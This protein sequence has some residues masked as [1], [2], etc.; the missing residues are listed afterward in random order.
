M[1]VVPMVSSTPQ[2]FPRFVVFLPLGLALACTSITGEPPASVANLPIDAGVPTHD[3]AT[4]TDAHDPSDAGAS[5]PDVWAM[6]MVGTRG[7]TVAAG[8]ATLSIPAGAL[9]GTQPIT[10]R[11]LG[12][13]PDGRA[14]EDLYQLS[15]AG[16]TF[17]VP[18]E[19][20]I[21]LG[22]AAEPDARLIITVPG[23]DTE[24]E[25][26][27]TTVS[28]RTLTA[29]ITH[30]SLATWIARG[31]CLLFRTPATKAGDEC[32]QGDHCFGTRLSCGDVPGGQ[33][34]CVCNF[35]G[36]QPG[37]VMCRGTDT[38]LVCEENMSDGCGEWS[39]PRGCGAREVCTCPEGRICESGCYRPACVPESVFFPCVGSDGRAVCASYD[40]GYRPR[41]EDVV[42]HCGECDNE[43]RRGEPCTSGMCGCPTGTYCS[44]GANGPGCYF[45]NPFMCGCNQVDCRAACPVGATCEDGVCGCN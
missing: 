25:T 30:F 33:R 9:N 39:A 14:A 32:C 23:S 42:T 12:T 5:T 16:L 17:A 24:F 20:G 38:E 29:T 19:L 3:A 45:D 34:A 36:C 27:A 6:A 43:C 26:L 22:A 11:E 4:S 41:G 40:I 44:A 1:I 21:S 35:R 13:Y 31:K 2:M 15:P 7:G 37:K 28:G 18:V 10:V 8:R